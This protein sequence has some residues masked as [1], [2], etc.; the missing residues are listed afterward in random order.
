MEN[1]KI[2]N[3]RMS[4]IWYQKLPAQCLDRIEKGFQFLVKQDG[5]PELIEKNDGKFQRP[6]QAGYDQHFWQNYLDLN[7]LDLVNKKNAVEKMLPLRER[8]EFEI[9]ID[10]PETKFIPEFYYFPFGVAFVLTFIYRSKDLSLQEAASLIQEIRSKAILQLSLKNG[11]S[12]GRE[13]TRLKM[14]AVKTGVFEHQYVQFFGQNIPID[15]SPPFSLFTVIQ[16]S[17]G[18]FSIKD[19]NEVHAFLN[20]V[21]KQNPKMFVPL[22]EALLAADSQRSA[23]FYFQKNGQAIWYPYLFTPG[24]GKRNKLSCYHR[25]Q[26]FCALMIESLGSSLED[27]AEKIKNSEPVTAAERRNAY[28]A[29]DCIGK[30][31]GCA[32]ETYHSPLSYFHIEGQPE[33]KSNINYVRSLFLCEPLY[34]TKA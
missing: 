15:N 12:E 5:I 27:Y 33:R 31:Y 2:N 9:K 24:R 4:F 30:L 22:K 11:T 6:W 34:I 3:F 26:L 25:N 32:K 19:G 18:D 29:A 8:L 17:G 7:N 16:G 21:T 20:Q 23:D 14:D 1:I 10:L 13:D 28:I